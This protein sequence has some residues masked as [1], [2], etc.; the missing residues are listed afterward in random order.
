M[1]R[2]NCT[3]AP[4]RFL[5]ST[6]QEDPEAFTLRTDAYDAWIDREPLKFHDDTNGPNAAWTWSTGDKVDIASFQPEKEDL[7][8]WAY[9]MWDKERLDRW[10]ILEESNEKY[11]CHHYDV[12]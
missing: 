12:E 3:S 6:L 10:G 1:L 8:K 4:R 5:T 2:K 11:V 7:R 9:V